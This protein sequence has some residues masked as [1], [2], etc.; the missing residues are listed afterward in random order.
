MG[1]RKTI[2][3]H[4]QMPRKKNHSAKLANKIKNIPSPYTPKDF[5]NKLPMS[6]PATPLSKSILG[7]SQG[8]LAKHINA[9]GSHT[10]AEF[11]EFGFPKFAEG[12]GGFE[13]IQQ[14]EA[15][16]I[17]MLSSVLGGTPQTIDGFFCGGGTESI[18]QGMWIG[19]E[20][21]N[22]KSDSA[23]KGIVV[24]TTPLGHYSIAKGVEL[25]GMG[26]H[27][28]GQCTRCN[29]NHIFNPDTNGCG[30]HLVGMNNSGEM[31]LKQLDKRFKQKFAEGFRKFMIVATVGTSL[32]GS[33][34]PIK[35][36]ADY[37]NKTRRE[38]GANFYLHIDAS[39]A[40][41]TVPFVAPD[42]Q[43]AFQIP[44]VMSATVDG[45]KMGQLPYPA[46]IFLCRKGLMSLVAKSVNY[47]RGHD[48]DTIPG[49]RSCLAPILAWYIMKTEGFDGQKMYV[50]NCLSL[51]DELYDRLKQLPIPTQVFDPNPWVNQLGVAINFSALNGVHN[52]NCG[53]PKMILEP[54]P[55]TTPETDKYYHVKGKLAAYHLRA[56]NF[57]IDP[58][59]T[60]SCPQTVYKLCIM[61]HHTLAS[62]DHFITDLV[63]VYNL[64]EEIISRS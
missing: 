46:G 11:D 38:T 43:F 37:I 5:P 59:D 6:Y 8:L 21:L 41:F 44:E 57:P 2:S 53:I 24:F 55:N 16:A 60:M 61:P 26:H 40:G 63:E 58:S 27:S 19:R 7:R 13:T 22:T 34:D 51:R 18:H 17:W 56:D 45:H 33:I 30:L 31:S 20:W 42:F 50:S 12:E 14:I 4:W 32:L 49:S 47:V 25:T 3:Y 35:E 54:R 9:I 52:A 15:E 23:K 28:W 1:R 62:F 64:W 10:H 36:I 29:K 39:F 48:D